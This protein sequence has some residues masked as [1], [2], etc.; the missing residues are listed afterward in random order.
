MLRTLLLLS[1]IL[2]F[3]VSAN[4]SPFEELDVLTQAVYE[5]EKIEDHPS[6]VVK[7]FLLDGITERREFLRDRFKD[8]TTY[9]MVNIGSQ[10]LTAVKDGKTAFSQKVIVG[11]DS[12]ATPLFSDDIKYIVTNPYWNVP[13]S[14]ATKDVIPKIVKDPSIAKSRGY[15]MLETKTGKVVKFNP[16]ANLRNYRMRQKPGPLNALGQIKFMFDPVPNRAIYLHDTPDKG[17]F[18]N[19]VRRYSSGCVRLEDPD[20]FGRFLMG[21]KAVPSSKVNDRW[22]KIPKAVTVHIVDWSVYVDQNG[23]IIVNDKTGEKYMSMDAIAS[24]VIQF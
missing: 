20:T 24:H 21:D 23:D 14:L 17:L 5:I 11:R 10:R 22:L 19:D 6:A 2:P 13:V 16:N 7:Q 1:T 18:E 12:R 8:K 4:M 9:V 3:A 15:E